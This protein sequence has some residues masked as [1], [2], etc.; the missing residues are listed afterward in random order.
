[1]TY[2]KNP[3]D[4]EYI[5]TYNQK[6]LTNI[7]GNTSYYYCSRHSD[8]C[9]LSDLFFQKPSQTQGFRVAKADAGRD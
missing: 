2:G 6:Q 9:Y 4:G 5:L 3:F 8:C 7:Y 1:M